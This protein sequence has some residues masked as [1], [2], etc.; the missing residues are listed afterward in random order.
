MS[1]VK[2]L[3]DT[4]NRSATLH[5]KETRHLWLIT[6]FC[7][8]SATIFWY[9]VVCAVLVLQ[10]VSRP[11]ISSCIPP[12]QSNTWTWRHTLD[13]KRSLK[14]LLDQHCLWAQRHPNDRSVQNKIKYGHSLTQLKR[15]ERQSSDLNPSVSSTTPRHSNSYYFAPPLRLLHLLLRM[16]PYKRN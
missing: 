15:E 14:L 11:V 16:Q 2:N 5:G 1:I 6:F 10:L 13:H 4:S 7:W 12:T 8:I 3:R 9:I